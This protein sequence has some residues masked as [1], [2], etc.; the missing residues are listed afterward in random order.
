MT[1]K[2]KELVKSKLSL[3][4]VGDDRAIN[5][6]LGGTES[7]TTSSTLNPSIK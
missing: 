7:R 3:I 5:Y 6:R 1:L 4:I 2:L